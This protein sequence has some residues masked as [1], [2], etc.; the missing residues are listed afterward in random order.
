MAP[1]L[2]HL[3]T[4]TNSGSSGRER[5]PDGNARSAIPHPEGWKCRS[6]SQNDRPELSPP[7]ASASRA[8]GRSCPK[9][10]GLD[11][12]C[13]YSN[14]ETAAAPALRSTAPPQPQVTLEI[15]LLTHCL[16]TNLGIDGAAWP[17]F[18]NALASGLAVL[19]RPCAV[20]TE[21][22]STNEETETDHR[23]ACNDDARPMDGNWLLSQQQ[24]ASIL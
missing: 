4:N 16:A 8:V 10:A 13:S 17:H 5:Q 24:F 14:P 6:G 3:I 23:I 1:R 15:A 2:Q 7:G 9:H 18:A 19:L 12:D 20:V 21:K 22:K 11:E